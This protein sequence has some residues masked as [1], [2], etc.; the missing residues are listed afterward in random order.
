[1]YKLKKDIKQ[2]KIETIEITEKYKNGSLLFLHKQYT[3]L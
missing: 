2:N 3:F 1:M